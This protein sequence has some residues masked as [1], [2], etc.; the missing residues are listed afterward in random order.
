MENYI[1]LA[2]IFMLVVSLLIVVVDNRKK[3]ILVE[4]QSKA[5]DKMIDKY[6]K[7]NGK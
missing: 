4:S 5:L 7:Q 2:L 3:T 6:V 1:Y